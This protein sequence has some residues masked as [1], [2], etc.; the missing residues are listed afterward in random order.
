MERPSSFGVK[1]VDVRLT[2][3]NLM[4]FTVGMLGWLKGLVEEIYCFLHKSLT[5]RR[6]SVNLVHGE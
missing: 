3:D 6:D 4:P 5:L 2:D 1:V